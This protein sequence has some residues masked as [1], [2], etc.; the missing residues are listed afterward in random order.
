VEGFH[1]KLV[2][3]RI[4]LQCLLVFSVVSSVC[5]DVLSHYIYQLPTVSMP[6]SSGG[7]KMLY[8]LAYGALLV[9]RAAA[10]A[11]CMKAPRQAT[12]VFY[13][14]HLNA[15]NDGRSALATDQEKLGGL[16]SRGLLAELSVGAGADQVG[17][18]VDYFTQA[19]GMDA[20]WSST[21][22]VKP[23]FESSSQAIVAVTLE[24]AAG[25][26]QALLVQLKPFQGCWKI[27]HVG[28]RSDAPL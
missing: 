13:G 10:E 2:K 28:P 27:A 24:Q 21:L 4:F 19:P 23:Q 22:E 14:W 1:E 3:C 5:R 11:V 20:G 6:A 7:V 8:P 18:G 17:T 16:V 15:I 26:K 9:Q 12:E 25:V